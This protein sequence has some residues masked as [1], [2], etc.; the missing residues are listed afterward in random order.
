MAEDA[1]I[2]LMGPS[3]SQIPEMQAVTVAVVSI[4]PPAFV[5]GDAKER[6][7]NNPA[8]GPSDGA[9]N[10]SPKSFESDASISVKSQAK[11]SPKSV[12]VSAMDV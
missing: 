3:L 6:S 9:A 7:K 2:V 4:A 5:N 8:S 11:G 1:T 12:V 10:E